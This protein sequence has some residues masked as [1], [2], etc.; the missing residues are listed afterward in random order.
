MASPV[1]SG[2]RLKYIKQITRSAARRRRASC[3]DVTSATPARVGS[4]RAD[5]ATNRCVCRQLAA[6]TAAAHLTRTRPRLVLMRLCDLAIWE[7]G[8][9]SAWMLPNSVDGSQLELTHSWI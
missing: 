8:V 1:A 2:P 9:Y 7:Q 4:G 5:R 3:S 6:P